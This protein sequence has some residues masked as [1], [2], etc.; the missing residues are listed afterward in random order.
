MMAIDLGL[1]KAN[2]VLPVVEKDHRMRV[3]LNI[4]IYEKVL[5]CEMGRPVLIRMRHCDPVRLSE[6][7]SD[8]YETLEQ[9]AS[10]SIDAP[11]VCLH[12]CLFFHFR[13]LIAFFSPHVPRRMRT[14]LS[15]LYLYG[16]LH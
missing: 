15:R 4:F 13:F 6:D 10:S 5:A 2:P 12:V 11:S 9:A 1:H 7:Q 16:F 8:E 3:F 14:D